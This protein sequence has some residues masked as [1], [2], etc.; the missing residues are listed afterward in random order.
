MRSFE[1]IFGGSFPK[2]ILMTQIA[3]F[4]GQSTLK[5]G[6]SALLAAFLYIIHIFR[7]REYHSDSS[8]T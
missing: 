5:V 1:C 2:C 7:S 6:L 3:I 8:S 4:S